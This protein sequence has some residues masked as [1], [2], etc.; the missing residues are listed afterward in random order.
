MLHRLDYCT[1][2]VL[3]LGCNERS[4]RR[5]SQDLTD[6][7]VQKQYKVPHLPQNSLAGFLLHIPCHLTAPCLRFCDVQKLITCILS[8][9][10]LTHVPVESGLELVHYMYPG[11]F[12][13]SLGVM[14]AQ[15]LRARGPRL[16]SHRPLSTGKD[17]KKCV[18]RITNTQV[19]SC[20]PHIPVRDIQM[21]C[22]SVPDDSMLLKNLFC[23]LKRMDA[24]GLR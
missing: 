5:F 7:K 23:M 20:L 6:H 10:V 4:C 21:A 11:P 22:A 8:A 19:A 9:Q 3:L 13:S 24:A 18:L 1:T 2:G 16:L 12:G 17:W 14:G 15:G